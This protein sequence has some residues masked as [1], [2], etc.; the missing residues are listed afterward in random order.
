MVTRINTAMAA[1]LFE[2]RWLDA[3]FHP[4]S[5]TPDAHKTY[6]AKK[7][8]RKHLEP[9]VAPITA[10]AR[11]LLKLITESNQDVLTVLEEKLLAGGASP[12]IVESAKS[13]RAN[14]TIMEFEN[15]AASL[16]DGEDILEDV[17]ERLRI[18]VESLLALHEETTRPAVQVWNTLLDR[19][20]QW[21]DTIDG[22]ALFR[23]DPDLLLGEVCQM[24]DLCQ[25]DWGQS[26]A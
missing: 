3:V 1:E 22:H 19:L 17:R 9:L 2:P 18:R 25:T 10:P 21:A 26:N 4:D 6:E 23:K 24:A 13:L 5:A 7:L 20:P 8:S 11:P 12:S 15:S 16:W 14:A